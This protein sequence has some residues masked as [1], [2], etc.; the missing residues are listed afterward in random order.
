[1]TNE[2]G[3]T[4]NTI[5]NASLNSPQLSS[6]L[7]DKPHNKESNDTDS[8]TSLIASRKLS[9]SDMPVRK[10]LNDEANRPNLNQGLDLSEIRFFRNTGVYSTRGAA[11]RLVE[12]NNV[13]SNIDALE[14]SLKNM[15]Q[16]LKK[17]LENAL[18]NLANSSY[19]I[20]V[21]E[22]GELTF[23][24]NNVNDTDN[25]TLNQLSS[26]DAFKDLAN[27]YAEEIVKLV[28]LHR[29][30]NGNGISIGRFDVTKENFSD[31]IDISAA[32]EAN[33]PRNFINQLI[34]K[35][36]HR[37]TSTIDEYINGEWVRIRT[38]G[39]LVDIEI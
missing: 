23:I 11:E 1:M 2:T 3:N 38:K 17:E 12:Q 15:Y 24:G 19:G 14:G 6:Q 31:I 25:K 4:A 33:V 7:L 30:A 16:N 22:K 8:S 26:S 39:E 32:L 36:E 18:P 37:D 10:D 29:D 21:D 13:S 27:E 9:A 35:A 20:S 28:E 34:N 5:R